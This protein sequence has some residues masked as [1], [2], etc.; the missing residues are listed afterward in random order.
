MR[1]YDASA[2]SLSGVLPQRVRRGDA[3]D[4]CPP[5]ARAVADRLAAVALWIATVFE[6]LLNALAVHWDILR[7]DL[8]YTARTLARTPGFALTAVLVVALGVGANT[9]AFTV[10][11]FVLIRP[12]PFP[13]ARPI[14]QAVGDDCRATRGWNYLRPTIAIGSGMSTFVRRH[15][16]VMCET[17]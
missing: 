5:Q 3:R 4:L 12:L 15:G 11:D 8:R 16:R 2:P 14:G 6:V 17:R 7:Q 9:A 10:T 1:F 13:R